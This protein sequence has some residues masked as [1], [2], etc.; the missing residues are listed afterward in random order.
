MGP[1][2]REGFEDAIDF[3]ADMPV[4]DNRMVKLGDLKIA[5]TVWIKVRFSVKAGIEG[6]FSL[7]RKAKLDP[8]SDCFSIDE[9]KRAWLSCAN[10]RDVRVWFV[11]K[12]VGSGTEHLGLGVELGVDFEAND[13]LPKV[14]G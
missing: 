8:F 3:S 2:D 11:A 10:D 14:E 9:R 5:G 1:I 4:S 13:R 7:D 12:V 6:H